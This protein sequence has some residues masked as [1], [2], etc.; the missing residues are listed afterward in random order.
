MGSLLSPEV[1]GK[2]N[3][4]SMN[5]LTGSSGNYVYTLNGLYDPD[6]SGG[7][8]QPTGFDEYMAMYNHY[9]VTSCSVR[10]IVSLSSAVPT[11]FC[12][13]PYRNSGTPPASFRDALA[14]GGPFGLISTSA[15]ASVELNLHVDVAR[16]QG[17]NLDS[18]NYAGSASANPTLLFYFGV[19]HESVDGSTSHS[20]NAVL[21]ITY[22]VKFYDRKPL[23]RS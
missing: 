15:G 18:V 12:L 5:E 23:S 19:F 14:L 10:A 4:S 22:T 21:R 20:M 2:L 6:I 13:T 3:Y 11:A 7:G 17:Y 1:T 16:W 9:R 8:A